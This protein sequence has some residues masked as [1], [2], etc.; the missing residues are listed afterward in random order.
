[1]YKNQSI[2]ILLVEDDKYFSFELGKVI[3]RFGNFD[4]C[5][6]ST[7]AEALLDQ[8]NYDLA[9]IDINLN[10]SPMPTGLRVLKKA[11]SKNI[12]SIV[13][14]NNEDDEITK[15]AYEL[16]CDH[17]LRKSSFRDSLEKYLESFIRVQKRINW[18]EYF[19]QKFITKNLALI[20]SI[21]NLAEMNLQNNAILLF[22]ATGTGKTHLAKLIHELNYDNKNFFHFNCSEVPETLIESELFGYHQGAFTGAKKTKKGLLEL[23]DNGTL[24]LDEI[25]TMPIYT[26]QKLLKVLEEKEFTPIGSTKPIKVNFTLISA[27]CE[28][29][30]Q[31]IKNGAFR[32]DLYYRI[33]GF[34]ITIPPLKSRAEDIELQL[35]HFLS[36]TSRKFFLEDEVVQSLLNYSWPGNTRELKKLIDNLSLAK[37][38]IISNSHPLITQ[39][40]IEK[41]NSNTL[42]T[43]NQLSFISQFGL[44]PFIHKVEKEA[45][46]NAYEQWDGKITDVIKALQISNSSFYRISNNDTQH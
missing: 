3:S 32:E 1:M 19:S 39:L 23:A 20:Q 17:F 43:R 40:K 2:S 13:L 42:L 36:K 14:S 15:K 10:S 24:F 45:V 33:N 38:G 30:H 18:N 5:S 34:E 21:Q 16:G 26:Q 12:Y 41:N 29:L 31:K 35:Y 28:K 44:K 6:S 27:T 22:G 11:S 9:I 8:N 7:Q 37:E 25:A 46:L 4:L